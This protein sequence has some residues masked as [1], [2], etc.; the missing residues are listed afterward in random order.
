MKIGDLKNLGNHDFSGGKSSVIIPS[1]AI[2][3][4]KR[5]FPVVMGVWIFKIPL[6]P[7]VLVFKTACSVDLPY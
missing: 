7:V 1:F 2:R 3:D 5:L 4:E 6:F